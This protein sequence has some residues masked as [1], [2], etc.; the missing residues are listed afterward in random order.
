[1]KFYLADNG[2]PTGPFEVN[3][4]IAR[5]LKGTDLVWTEGYAQWVPAESVEELRTAMYTPG[6]SQQYRETAIPEMP[7]MP[8]N[9]QCPPPPFRPQ[10]Q[11]P[12]QPQPAANY[13][14]CPKTWLVESI[15]V[16][17]FCCIPFGIV[18]IIK[19]SK[20]SSL[21]G[22]GRIEEARIASSQAKKWTLVALIC[23][24][25]VMVLQT[26]FLFASGGIAAYLE[27][28]Q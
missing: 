28:I 22:I 23:G 20:V 21:Y 1:M 17:I 4:L 5:G 24:L 15:L 27:S 16:T 12:M 14:P 18:A 26:I 10:Y 6:D 7:S 8:G 3:E 19:S 13:E 25:V 2:Q 9:T 11:Q